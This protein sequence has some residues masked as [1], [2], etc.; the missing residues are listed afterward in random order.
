MRGYLL[1]LFSSIFFCIQNVTVRL[2]FAE[3]AL[4]GVGVTGGFLTPTLQ[5]SFLLLLLR[6]LL[7]APLMAVLATRIYP[8]TWQ[9]L[10]KLGDRAQRQ[11]LLHVLLG[12]GLM[13]AY[14]GLLYVAIGLI[15]TGIA[16]TLFFTFPVFTALF[17]WRFFGHRPSAALWGVMG[18][19][20]LGGMLTVPRVQWSGGG[21]YWGIV[22][23]IGAGI[24]YALY[25]VNAQKSFDYVHPVLYTWVSFAMTL[26]L[27][28]LCLLVWPTPMAANLD[29]GPIWF[30]SLISGFVT[31]VG[32]V[33]Y[34]SGIRLIGATAAGMIGSANPAFTV[35]LAWIVIQETLS[36]VQVLGVVMVTLS[37]AALSRFS[38]QGG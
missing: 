29:W 26:V 36:I 27:S 16:M 38:R 9:D 18:C 12:G 3:Q 6:M 33:L 30:W 10:A 19:V 28:A 4:L 7:A 35:L 5:N 21:S 22:F 20:L 24:A 34:N 1:I 31:F 32:H 37:V 13:F 25:T 14:L 11:A 17:S 2:L 8:A 15:A 23:G